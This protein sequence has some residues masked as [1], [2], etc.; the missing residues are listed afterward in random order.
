MY[1]NKKYIY[2]TYGIDEEDLIQV[3]ELG[4]WLAV[5]SYNSNKSAIQT[6][7]INMIKWTI[8]DYIKSL[9]PVNEQELADDYILEDEQ[10]TES[11][12]VREYIVTLK[13]KLTPR[14]YRILKMVMKE[15]TQRDIGK[16]LGVSRTIVN[17]EMKV[18]R[19]KY[20]ELSEENGLEYV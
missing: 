1:E 9:K 5:K 4:I 14:Q 3:G 18:I 10:Q 6:H 2:R 11:T 20:E 16:E 13:D 17:K 15:M 7:I 12:S 19:R 8:R